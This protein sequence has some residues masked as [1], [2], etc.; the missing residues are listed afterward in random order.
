MGLWEAVHM[1][2]YVAYCVALLEDVL[3]HAAWVTCI[4]VV[5]LN[6]KRHFWGGKICLL[7]WLSKTIT[8]QTI[9]TIFSLKCF[10]YAL[11]FSDEKRK[12]VALL[13]CHVSN[14]IF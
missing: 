2:I 5:L 6:V 9:A 13:V 4:N 10:F 1:L 8:T 12:R 11:N 14:N 7:K 3:L